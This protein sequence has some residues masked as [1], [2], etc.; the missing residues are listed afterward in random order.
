MPFFNHVSYAYEGTPEGYWIEP[1]VKYW[2]QQQQKYI[3]QGN[4]WAAAACDLMKITANQY[5][6]YEKA[7]LILGDYTKST[8]ERW[9]AGGV[10]AWTVVKEVVPS[11][12][13]IKAPGGEQLM[14]QITENKIT[15]YIQPSK[16]LGVCLNFAGNSNPISLPYIGKLLFKNGLGFTAQSLND[17]WNAL[18]L[19]YNYADSM[20]D[21]NSSYSKLTPDA[22]LSDEGNNTFMVNSTLNPKDFEIEVQ[23]P[24]SYPP[25]ITVKNN[26]P[27]VINSSTGQTTPKEIIITPKSPSNSQKPTTIAESKDYSTDYSFMDNP[28]WMSSTA[29]VSFEKGYTPKN[30]YDTVYVKYDPVRV[31]ALVS[32]VDFSSS[33]YAVSRSLFENTTNTSNTPNV[34]QGSQ[35]SYSDSNDDW[36]ER[37][38]AEWEADCKST[39][40]FTSSYYSGPTYSTFRIVE[41]VEVTEVWYED[42]TEI[43]Y[44]ERNGSITIPITEEVSKNV[45]L[46]IPTTELVTETVTKYLDPLTNKTYEA[47]ELIYEVDGKSYKEDDLFWLKEEKFVFNKTERYFTEKPAFIKYERKNGTSSGYV[48]ENYTIFHPQNITKLIPFNVTEF[49]ETNITEMMPVNVTETVPYYFDEIVEYNYTESVPVNITETIIDRIWSDPT[50]GLYKTPID[51]NITQS[52]PVVNPVIIGR[53]YTQYTKNTVNYQDSIKI[54]KLIPVTITGN[55]TTEIILQTQNE[56]INH[57]TSLSN[58]TQNI[59]PINDL[60]YT[61]QLDDDFYFKFNYQWVDQA[62]KTASGTYITYKNITRTIYQDVVKTGFQ[63]VT[64]VGYQNVTSIKYVPQN[65]T[66]LQNYTRTE[67]NPVNETIMVPEIFHNIRRWSDNITNEYIDISIVDQVTDPPS[68]NVWYE[69]TTKRYAEYRSI[70]VFQNKTTGLIRLN[71]TNY[72]SI[73][74]LIKVNETTKLLPINVTETKNKTYL[75]YVN[76]TKTENKTHLERINYTYYEPREYTVWKKINRTYYERDTWIA[77]Y[78]DKNPPKPKPAGYVYGDNTDIGLGGTSYK[79]ISE[80]VE[81]APQSYKGRTQFKR[82][83]L[84]EDFNVVYSYEI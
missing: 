60:F 28:F 36:F 47:D 71:S 27:S 14:W 25:L 8:K 7:T 45:T 78:M 83:Y 13:K 43:Y 12:L 39:M 76:V 6:S 72:K 38:M 46:T 33:Y 19:L 73:P 77:K 3:K 66:I 48:Y 24:S 26:N 74:G 23:I 75:N 5:S 17:L 32:G 56:T 80:T 59:S 22:K 63:N 69:N 53:N 11:F 52:V 55:N 37:R 2:E 82:E 20:N 70:P 67:Y 44:S 15:T 49:L 41:L 58:F 29:L 65:R 4:G 9:K 30:T 50:I 21:Y 16:I 42:V 68:D 84:D 1:A 10:V 64:K 40:T 18:N 31:G 79:V 35:S 57:N 54:T 62:Y 61:T 51:L 81:K 34:N